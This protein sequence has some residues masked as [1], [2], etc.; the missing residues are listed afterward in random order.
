MSFC[1]E[2]VATAF[3][4]LVKPDAASERAVAGMLAVMLAL[5]GF[6][7]GKVARGRRQDPRLLC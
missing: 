2:Q 5:A 7:Q 1:T 4:G 3:V 6:A